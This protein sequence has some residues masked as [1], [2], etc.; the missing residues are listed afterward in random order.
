MTRRRIV[1]LVLL[2]LLSLVLVD[3]PLLAFLSS[4]RSKFV[5]AAA[6]KLTPAEARERHE[7]IELCTARSI[8]PSTMQDTVEYF[9]E[10]DVMQACMLGLGFHV[11]VVDE[12]SK[13]SFNVEFDNL[14]DK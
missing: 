4:Q 3:L 1:R 5:P 10:L 7:A 14:T 11:H 2:G 8:G 13:H 6:R 9:H 12:P